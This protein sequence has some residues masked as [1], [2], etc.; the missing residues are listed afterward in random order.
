MKD[1]KPAEDSK[2]THS[3][4]MCSIPNDRSLRWLRGRYGKLGS[5][6]SCFCKCGRRTLRRSPSGADQIVSDWVGL[7]FA[8]ALRAVGEDGSHLS[9][10]LLGVGARVRAD[11]HELVLYADP[12]VGCEHAC[13][14]AGHASMSIVDRPSGCTRRPDAS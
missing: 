5:L 10:G 2:A 13:E 8:W 12:Y 14:Q 6:S 4:M 1:Q 9:R 7:Q 11:G 3:V